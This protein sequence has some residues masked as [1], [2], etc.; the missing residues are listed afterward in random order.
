MRR[1]IVIKEKAI[2]DL[3]AIYWQTV[4]RWGRGQARSY[5]EAMQGVFNLLAEQPEL[6]RE[7]RTLT[8]PVRVHPFRSHIVIYRADDDFLDILRVLHGRS[9]WQTALLT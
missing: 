3:D 5:F 9:N 6:A 7:R 1:Q 2:A 4:E 8:P